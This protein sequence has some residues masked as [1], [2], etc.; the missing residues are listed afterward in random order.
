[1]LGWFVFF[2][3]AGLAAFTIV[4]IHVVVRKYDKKLAEGDDSVDERKKLVGSQEPK[5]TKDEFEQ[6]SSKTQSQPVESTSTPAPENIEEH[7]VDLGADEAGA[8][9][10]K[11]DNADLISEANLDVSTTRKE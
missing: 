8:E 4:G 1:M 10:P 9:I 11:N 5:Q 6:G 3:Q 7:K 2:L